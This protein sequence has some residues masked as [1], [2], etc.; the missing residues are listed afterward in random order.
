MLSDLLDIVG[1]DWM[2]WQDD[3]LPHADALINL[4]GG[5][6]E[7]RVLATERLVVES[8]R[9]NPTAL[10]IAVSPK[11]DEMKIIAPLVYRPVAIPRLKQCEDLVSNNCPNFE[12]MRLEVD[13]TLAG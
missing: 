3:A 1:Q 13:R 8:L 12:T 2:G 9:L 5:F 4:C 6:T 7:Q 10:Q 11:D